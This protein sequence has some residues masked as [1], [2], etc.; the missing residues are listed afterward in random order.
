[1]RTGYPAMLGSRKES[2][3]YP[4]FVLFCL[5]LIWFLFADFY[6]TY[7]VFA[8]DVSGA[9][10]E[11]TLHTGDILYADRTVKAR[12]GDIVI[13]DVTPYR[14]QYDFTSH[15]II[16]R[17]IATEGDTVRC[18][19]GVVSVRYAGDEAFTPLEEPYANGMTDSFGEVEVGKGQIFFLGDNRGN[20]TDSRILGC[21]LET[22][23]SGAVV[24]WSLGDKTEKNRWEVF[25]RSLT[26]I[27]FQK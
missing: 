27:S 21:Y 7:T 23:I 15:Y 1:M 14:G 19:N 4:A 13:I 9:S 17:L 10:M 2:R 20:S 22:D 8:V 12:R 25:W 5:L 6:V 16:K 24:D 3:G 26:E 18:E 11:R